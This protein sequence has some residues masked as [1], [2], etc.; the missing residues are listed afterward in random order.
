VIDGDGEERD[1]LSPEASIGRPYEV[2]HS[3]LDARELCGNLFGS[4]AS[5]RRR[6]ESAGPPGHSDRRDAAAIDA[7]SHKVFGNSQGNGT[8]WCDAQA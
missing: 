5:S 3:W 7:A 4:N 1:E 8:E 6:D 2:L